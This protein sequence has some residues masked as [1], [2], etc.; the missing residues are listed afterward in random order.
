MAIQTFDA[1]GLKCPQPTLKLTVMAM[2]KIKP[3]DMLEMTADCP[4]FENDLRQWCSRF[5]KTLLWVRDEGGMKR[6][7]I[8]F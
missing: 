1:T 6:C 3:G 5:R 8:Q 4:T 2:T 7:Q